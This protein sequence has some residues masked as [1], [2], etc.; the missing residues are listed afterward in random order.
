MA[1]ILG[2]TAPE[3]E[4]VIH[5][6]AH[7]LDTLAPADLAEGGDTPGG[8]V[9]VTNAPLAPLYGERL[10]AR[11][12]A[13]LIVVPE[14]EAH[15]TLETVARVYDGLIAAKADRHT[16]LIALGGGVVGDMAGFAAASYMRGIRF[17]QAP[18]SLLAMVDSSVGGKV[19]VDLPQGKN[20]VGAFYPPH[21]VVID[22]AVLA[23]L[24]DREW[25]CG[26]AEILKHGLIAA[27]DL[28]A[29]IEADPAAFTRFT[30][31]DLAEAL[32]A[33]AVQVKIDVVEADPYEHGVRAHLNLGHTFGH[34]IE[35]VTAY[36]VPHGE[37]VGLGLI[38]AAHLS[39]ALGLCAPALVERV[40]AAVGG[41]GLPTHFAGH[42]PA[43]VVAAMATDKKF[44][45]GSSRFV[46]M[47]DVGHV[48]IARDVPTEAVEAAVA[49]L[50]L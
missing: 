26:M 13:A 3:R 11:L 6:A 32:V 49:A 17:V 8:F 28:F 48:A 31:A 9:V 19:G 7:L 47:H 35:R 46:V 14:G 22:P 20:L 41:V 21:R 18:T 38:A 4:Y 30:N 24:P 2:V 44:A 37:A 27:P 33:R 36:A 34:A 25:R 5:M 12:G 23:T 43:D 50:A 15:K 1:R 10:A 42:R 39:A 40:R 16:T 29:R 45:A